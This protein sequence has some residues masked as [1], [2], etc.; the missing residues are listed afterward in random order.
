MYGKWLHDLQDMIREL[1]GIQSLVSLLTAG[2]EAECTHRAL[3]ALRILT[4]KE[5]DRLAILKAGGIDHLVAL[6]SAGPDSEVTEYA[7][8]ALGNLAAGSQQVK[9]AIRQVCEGQTKLPC[10]IVV[11]LIFL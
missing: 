11:S 5:A 1:G 8:A 10:T 2:P 3:L 9:D 4:D 6:L 7:A